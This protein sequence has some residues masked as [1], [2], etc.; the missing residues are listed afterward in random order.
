MTAFHPSRPLVVGAASLACMFQWATA[1][2]QTASSCSE[3][4]QHNTSDS[5]TSQ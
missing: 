1:T 5:T 3:R 4:R 2:A